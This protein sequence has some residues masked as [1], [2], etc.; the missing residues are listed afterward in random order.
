MK[1]GRHSE[2]MAMCCQKMVILLY[3]ALVKEV[4]LECLIQEKIQWKSIHKHY[5]T[6]LFWKSFKVTMIP[7]NHNS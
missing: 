2:S 1:M 7:T 6:Y 4:K 3:I 5:N